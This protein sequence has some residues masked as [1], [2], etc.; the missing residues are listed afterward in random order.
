[1]SIKAPESRKKIPCSIDKI[2]TSLMYLEMFSNSLSWVFFCFS[3][4]LFCLKMLFF[5][6]SIN[7]L[8]FEAFFSFNRRSFSAWKMAICHV[9][10]KEKESYIMITTLVLS[11]ASACTSFAVSTESLVCALIISLVSLQRKNV[12]RRQPKKNAPRNV[13]KKSLMLRKL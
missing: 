13:I 10:W 4:F 6:S 9:I 5:R 2:H 7:F 1:M 8:V 3:R 12:I 11:V